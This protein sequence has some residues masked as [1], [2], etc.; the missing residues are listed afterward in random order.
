MLFSRNLPEP[1]DRRHFAWPAARDGAIDAPR[2]QQA[3]RSRRAA[4]GC[5]A[6]IGMGFL[7]MYASMLPEQPTSANFGSD[8]GDLAAAVLTGGIPHPT[9]YPVYLLLGRLFVVLPFSTP[10]ARLALFSAV[11]GAL[12]A[13]LTF[14]WVWS[15]SG[16]GRSGANWLAALGAALAWG[17]APL[18]WSQAVIVEVHTLQALFVLAWLAWVHLL[19]GGSAGRPAHLLGC[20]FL[21]GLSLGNHLTILLLLPVLGLVLL[22]AAQRGISRR[23]LLGQA[24]ALAAG[25]LIYLVL[26]WQARA[27]P[28]V[29]WGNPQSLAGLWWLISAEPYRGLVFGISRAEWLLRGLEWG[30]Q[31]FSQ[32]GVVGVALGGVGLVRGTG[33]R[34]QTRLLL[35][36]LFA[37]ATVFSLGYNTPDAQVYLIPA[38]LVFAIWFGQG[39]ALVWRLVWRGV[40]VGQA[41]ALA[42]LLLLVG[43]TLPTRAAVDPRSS[44]GQAEFTAELLN[45]APV[46]AFVVT[47]GDED[48]FP[49]W[50]AHYGLGQRSDLRVVVQPLTQFRWYQETLLKTYPDL[51]APLLAE[52]SDGGWADELLA[53]NP[54]HPVCR[55]EKEAG[56]PEKIGFSCRAAP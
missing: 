11:A 22:L 43:R 12:A 36:W 15:I 3:L 33:L 21:G 56:L 42:A 19:L 14:A 30:R 20:A 28:P 46:G 6:L 23:L 18:V 47:S 5:A 51:Q 34:L 26:P 48:S 29:N 35:V 1:S 25:S 13:A 49:L 53:L 2:D 52:R 45:Q 39:L 37:A 40:R 55:S 8:G 16:H 27:W 31:L 24:V 4:W 10:Y 44:T 17:S 54:A 9:G 7:L 32:F 50:Y 38:Y 41:L